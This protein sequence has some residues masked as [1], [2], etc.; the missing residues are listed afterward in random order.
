VRIDDDL[1]TVARGA[2]WNEEALPA[3]T[4]LAGLVACDRVYSREA[5]GVTAGDL[6]DGF[7]T[8]PLLLQI[9]GKATVGRGRVRCVFTAAERE[10]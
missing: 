1:K 6:I 10:G 7:A 5:N 3:E 4:I 8:K 9:G 2:L